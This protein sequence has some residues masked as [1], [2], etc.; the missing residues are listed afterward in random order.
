VTFESLVDDALSAAREITANYGTREIVWLG[1]RF[2]ALVAAAAS[3]RYGRTR[4]ISL[5]APMA[6]GHDYTLSLVRGLRFL[7][8]ARG[9]RSGMPTKDLIRE[10]QEK[11][12]VELLGSCVFAKFYNAARKVNLRDLMMGWRGPTFLAQIQ[13]RMRLSASNSALVT[14]LEH[15]GARIATIMIREEPGWHFPMW[16]QPWIAS[17]LLTQTGEWL[18]AVA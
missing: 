3:A 12:Y 15:R 18:D 4:A 13:P 9:K 17:D 8:I 14:E 10:I 5:W 7:E 6:T 16:R 1:L 2:G 11:G